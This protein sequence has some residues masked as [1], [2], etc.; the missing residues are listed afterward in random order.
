MTK[1]KLFPALLFILT[2]AACS[3]TKPRV[4]APE[5]A[6]SAS[7]KDAV[8]A[9]PV[10]EMAPAPVEAATRP[11][12]WF[13]EDVTRSGFPGVSVERAY[14]T[15]LKDRKPVQSVVVAVIDSG[16][17]IEHEDLQSKIWVNEDEVPGNNVDDDGNGYV[18]DIHG[19]DFIGGADGKDVDKDTYELTREFARLK[20]IFDDKVLAELPDSQQKQYEY[21][22]KLKEEYKKVTGKAEQQYANASGFLHAAEQA[23]K[24]VQTALGKEE[25]TPA[26][27]DGLDTALPG[28]DRASQVMRFMFANEFTLVELRD[29]VD[30]LKEDVDFRYNLD[31][32]PRTIVGDDYNDVNQRIYGNADVK[33]PDPSHGTHVAGIIGA[34]RNNGIGI[35][36]IAAPVRI[37]VIRTVPDG[38]E[39]DKDVANAIR[40]AVDNGAKIVNMSFGKA[41]SPQKA[42]VDAAVRYAEA[43]HVL[44]VHAAGNGSDDIDTER[45]FPTRT[46]LDGTQ[47][48]NWIEVGASSW[49]KGSKLAAGFSNYGKHSVDLFAPG[50]AIYSTLPGQKYG[51]QQGTSMAAPVVTGV[52]ALILAYHPE[53]TPEKLRAILVQSATSYAGTEVERPGGSGAMVDFGELS[54]SGGVVNAYSALIM[55]DGRQP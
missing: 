7:S 53:L 5:P 54:V 3:S 20:P 11:N 21:Y 16:V 27:L 43:H 12:D 39:R 1:L 34:A 42:A 41:Y 45:N 32:N 18:D 48:T 31:Y 33:G 47:A 30:K 4:T 15:V 36:G 26:D 19:W 8:S 46:F 17:D 29:Y 23:T 6:E 2:I 35:N 13:E 22:L 38:D 28:L 25:I 40:Y 37:M 49:Q 24:L 14:K 44:L 52:A 10:S 50:V 9:E 51:E 55:A